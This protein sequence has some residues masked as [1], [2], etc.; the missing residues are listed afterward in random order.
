MPTLRRDELDTSTSVIKDT[1]NYYLAR[2]L[3]SATH[4]QYSRSSHRCVAVLDQKMPP[5][6]SS[7]LVSGTRSETVGD[8]KPLQYC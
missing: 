3:L 5:V 7:F 6:C 2:R 8:S 4:R 1:I